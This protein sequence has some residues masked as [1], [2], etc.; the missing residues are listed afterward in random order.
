M[1]FFASARKPIPVRRTLTWD[2]LVSRLS[3]LRQ[4]GAV[5]TKEARLDAVPCWSP[6]VFED[7][8]P[9]SKDSA[10]RVSALVLDYDDGTTLEAACAAWSD[11]AAVLHT[12]WSHTDDTHRCRVV[13]P[14]SVPC[15]VEMWPRIWTWAH[16]RAPGIDPACKDASRIYFLPTTRR[17]DAPFEAWANHGPPLDVGNLELPVVDGTAPIARALPGNRTRAPRPNDSTATGRLLYRLYAN[18]P[19]LREEAARR[20]GALLVDNRATR[21]PCPACGRPSVWWWIDPQRQVTAQCDHRNTCGWYGPVFELL[22]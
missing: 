16:R 10:L 22:E 3:D 21:A 18:R 19:D 8:Q 1:S 12:S 20:V 17:H 2:A 13:V 7:G 6:C 4:H 15:P 9:R 11:W 14:L 5:P